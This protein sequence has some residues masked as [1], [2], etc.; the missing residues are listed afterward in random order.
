MSAPSPATADG[1][2]QLAAAL[3][4]NPTAWR[5]LL[6]EHTLTA[7]GHCR[8]CTTGGTGMRVTP[9]PCGPQRLAERARDIAKGRSR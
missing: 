5:N 6:A 7:T 4:S 2:E 1:W 8:A 9:W 3:A